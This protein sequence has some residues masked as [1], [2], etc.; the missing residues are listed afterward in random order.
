MHC[1]TPALPGVSASNHMGI[2]VIVLTLAM[3]LITPPVGP[4]LLIAAFPW[5]L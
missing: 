4:R 5:A 1:R 2:I 3:G